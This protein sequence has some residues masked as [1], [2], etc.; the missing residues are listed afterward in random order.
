MNAHTEMVEAS[1]FVAV[2]DGHWRARLCSTGLGIFQDAACF[3]ELR[4][5]AVAVDT[6]RRYRTVVVHRRSG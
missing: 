5:V 6:D 2:D 4:I 3:D 1:L